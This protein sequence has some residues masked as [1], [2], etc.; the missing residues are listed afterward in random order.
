MKKIYSYDLPTN[1]SSQETLNQGVSKGRKITYGEFAEI[2][3]RAI[4]SDEISSAFR[5]HVLNE[6]EMGPTGFSAKMRKMALTEFPDLSHSTITT[7]LLIPALSL[8]AKEF[9][10]KSDLTGIE[11]QKISIILGDNRA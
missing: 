1:P 11:R 8:F 6:S 9:S 5:E 7:D 3:D 10:K 2:V 4:R